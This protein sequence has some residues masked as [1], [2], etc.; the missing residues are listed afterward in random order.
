MRKVNKI[1]K[2]LRE[3]VVIMPAYNEEH[4]IEQALDAIAVADSQAKATLAEVIICIN[5][6][7]DKTEDIVSNYTK[8]PL[9]VIH[10][11]PGYL[12][13]MNRLIRYA[14]KHYPS[15]TM[16]KTDADST[17]D[18]KALSIMFG[19]L[20]KHSE[21]VLVG[22]HPM[23]LSSGELPMYQ[24]LSGRML[25][26]R[27]R[28]PLSEMAVND[29]AAFHPFVDTD[30]QDGIGK[31]EKR[32]KI[33][34][35]GRLWCAV[36]SLSVPPLHNKVIGDDVYLNDLLYKTH[37]H[38]AIR[39]MYGATCYFRPYHS[40]SRHWKV[41]KRIHEDKE[42]VRVL[43]GIEHFHNLRKTKLNWRYI[44]TSVPVYDI[45]LFLLFGALRAAEEFS[46]AR[47]AY[48]NSYWQYTEKES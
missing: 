45:L 21:L 14:R 17:L 36:N 30:P 34:F 7:T 41:Y 11:S 4:S 12:A 20:D 1:T 48:K 35:H 18:P 25:S 38:M 31:A 2:S 9:K 22:G 16:V 33:Y 29:V 42:R 28:Y 32:T 13:A 26:V 43:P 47:T 46:F 15:H 3:Y 44:F 39:V 10:S 24:K 23:P 27:N 40:I 5:G 6:C 8:L 19:Q 37:G